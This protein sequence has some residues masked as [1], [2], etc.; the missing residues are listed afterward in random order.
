MSTKPIIINP[1][2]YHKLPVSPSPQVHIRR[3]DVPP[4]AAH[5][6]GHPRVPAAAERG[7]GAGA[8]RAKPTGCHHGPAGGRWPRVGRDRGGSVA[9]SWFDSVWESVV[10]ADEQL[11]SRL[12]SR[13]FAGD[14]FAVRGDRSASSGGDLN[15]IWSGLGI[16]G[17]GGN[18][19]RLRWC[20]FI[21]QTKNILDL[22]QVCGPLS[23]MLSF[24]LSH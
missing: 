2:K 15:Y 17:V 18:W 20:G 9:E 10:G 7:S 1:N 23:S 14:R 21:S 6:T 24:P 22:Y 12:L 13:D 11:G 16:D 19:K 8:F 4:G 5:G 3:W